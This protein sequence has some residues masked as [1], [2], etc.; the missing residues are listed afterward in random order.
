MLFVKQG[1][2][3]NSVLLL[4]AV[5]LCG[6]GGTNPVGFDISRD[7]AEQV[8][9]GDPLAHAAAGV[10]S[11]SPFNPFMISVDLSAESRANGNVV[12]HRV[13]LQALSFT[14]TATEQ[15]AGDMDCWDFIESIEVF[16]SSTASSTTLPRIRIASATAPGCVPTLALTPV[17]DVNLKPDIEEGARIEVEASGIPPADNVSFDGQIVVRAEPF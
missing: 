15:P 17:A 4:A 14:M 8:V 3:S 13:L 16:A 1:I 2:G 5:A 7:V 10:F 11:A 9:H 12:V 6:C